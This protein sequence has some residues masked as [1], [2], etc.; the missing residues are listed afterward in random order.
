MRRMLGPW[1]AKQIARLLLKHPFTVI[2]AALLLALGAGLVASR[3]EL[4]T[5]FSALLP[6]DTP[7]VL[8]IERL[9]ERIGGAAELIVAVSGKPE[10]RLRYARALVEALRTKPWIRRAD[11][12]FPVDFFLERK[13]LL[14]PLEELRR[15]ESALAEEIERVKARANPLF[16]DLEEDGAGPKAWKTYEQRA[17]LVESEGLL[18]RT[19]TSDDGRYLFVRVLPKGSISEMAEGARLLAK[20]EA[21]VAAAKP[22]DYGVGVRLA[23][24]LPLNQEQHRRMTSD[25]S[26]ASLIAFAL[27]LLLLTA[28]LRRVEALLVLAIPLTAGICVTFAIA[29]LTIGQLNLVS[30]LLVS[31]LIGLGIDF[32]IHLYAR[33]LEALHELGVPREAM[34]VAVEST[35]PSCL[36]AALT[37]AAAFLAMTFTSFRGF[38]EYG[39]IAALGVIVTLVMT[40]VTLPPLARGLSRRSRLWGGHH[41]KVREVSRGLSFTFVIVGLV[42]AGVS[43]HLIGK[44]RYRNDFQKLRGSSETVAFSDEVDRAFGGSL[45]PAAILVEGVGRA[46]EVEQVLKELKGRDDSG[47]K[48]YLSLASMVPD[49]SP[50]RERVRAKMLKDLRSLPLGELEPDDRR[51]VEQALAQLERPAWTAEQIPEAYRQQFMTLDQRGTLVLVWP[52]YGM[53]EDAEVIAWGEELTALQAR[54]REKGIQATILDENRVAARVLKQ[55]KRDAPR[56]LLYAA[57]AILA[58]LAL[59][60]RRPRGVLFVGGALTIGMVWFLGLTQLLGFEINVFNQ[61]VIPSLLGLG[62]DNAVHLLH[63]YDAEGPGSLPLVVSTTGSASFLA[64]GTTGIGFGAAVTAYHYGVQ[65]MGWLAIIG[66]TCTFLSTTVFFPALLRLLEGRM[67]KA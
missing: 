34:F 67:V 37:T 56:V 25:L 13:L 58:I 9:R 54:L 16:V 32:G 48:R 1:I 28:W 63:R 49:P 15:V 41:L 60:F 11:A 17:K 66:F 31:A 3:L 57:L 42:L 39:A 64:S 21:V 23:G 19:F 2:T 40:Y 7:E 18:R 62:V 44:L 53:H 6:E 20:I 10:A 51:Q 45:A 52:R 14:L 12:E 65:T 43:F 5:S 36:T 22:S 29:K 61:A 24:G 47:V 27:V 46:R 26:R 50:E 59:D 55:M 35:F 30:G 4:D 8:E 33:Y 38:S